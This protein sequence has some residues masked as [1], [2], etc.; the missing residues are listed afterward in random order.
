MRV[1]NG[2]AVSENISIQELQKMMEASDMK[3]F[4]IACE[5]LRI[6][7]NH[8]AYEV[9]KGYVDT[10]DKYKYRCV[11]S[12]IFEYNEAAELSDYLIRA[13][14]SQ[15]RFLVTVA[16][17][18]LVN[19]N[20]EI[21]DKYIIECFERNHKWLESYYYQALNT[22]EK[23]TENTERIISLL[24]SA[25]SD[26]V[27]IAIAE[28]LENFCT[29]ENHLRL[30][31]MFAN[32]SLAKVRM[33]ACRIA[34]KFSRYDLLQRYMDDSD[35]HIRKYIKNYKDDVVDEEVERG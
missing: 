22:I 31:E 11:L 15:E 8:E 5:A 20:I 19:K 17:N 29:E 7:N 23:I 2:Q 1:L 4:A 16:L 34:C 26:S 30:F 32:S 6:A 18:H 9:L 35:G 3:N 33:V 12:A 24:G 14:Q 27:R 13:L 21:S 10:R 28:C 25:S